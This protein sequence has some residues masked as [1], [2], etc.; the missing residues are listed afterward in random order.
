MT[1][2]EEPRDDPPSMSGDGSA[3]MPGG[4][5]LALRGIARAY[6]TGSGPL[7]VLQNANLDQVNGGY[8]YTGCDSAC[9]QCGPDGR[10]TFPGGDR[11]TGG[12]DRLTG[13]LTDRLT[14]G[15]GLTGQLTGGGTLGR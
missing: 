5:V 15:G 12:G 13:N 1:D 2:T 4:A 7:H 3:G 14:G 10:R 9:T 8:A 6:R 11:I